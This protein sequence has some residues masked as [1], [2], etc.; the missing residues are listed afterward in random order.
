MAREIEG[1]G[2]PPATEHRRVPGVG[3]ETTAVEERRSRIVGAPD[4]RRHD[5]AVGTVDVHALPLGRRLQFDAELGHFLEQQ[6][7][8]VMRGGSH[9]VLSSG[10]ASSRRQRVPASSPSKVTISVGITYHLGATVRAVPSP[11]QLSHH[12]ASLFD[13]TGRTAL[14]VGG[15][16]GIGEAAAVG[17]AAFGARRD[18][19]R[20]PWERRRRRGRP[21]RRRR[22]RRGARPPRPIGGRCPRDVD[23]GPGRPRHRRRR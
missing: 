3:V 11:P 7:Q 10:G 19:R 6:L 5:A 2:R 13:L 12:F 17:L 18:R 4:D 1:H 15:G 20:R 9:D 21:D 22:D 8:I 23:R 16:S 14:V